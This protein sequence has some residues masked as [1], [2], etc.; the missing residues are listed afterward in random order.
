MSSAGAPP[1]SEPG[2]R[3]WSSSRTW[4]RRRSLTASAGVQRQRATPAVPRPAIPRRC[5]LADVLPLGAP[6]IS[7]RWSRSGPGRRTGCDGWGGQFG[8]RVS[9]SAGGRS[10]LPGRRDHGFR[11][12]GVPADS[13]RRP[14]GQPSSGPR[15]PAFHRFQGRLGPGPADRAPALRRHAHGS[16]RRGSGPH[17]RFIAGRGAAEGGVACPGG[18]PGPRGLRVVP[19][20]GPADAVS[21]DCH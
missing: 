19:G 1:S 3:P 2:R 13:C 10:T 16:G 7:R 17:P 9:R 12:I 14:R 15:Q 20:P 11:Q 4:S 18:C 5:S 21:G 6:D 8:F